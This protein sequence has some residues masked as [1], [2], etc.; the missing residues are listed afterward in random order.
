MEGMA[1]RVVSKQGAVIARAFLAEFA[2]GIGDAFESSGTTTS[3]TGAGIIETL[4]PSKTAQT[5]L[6]S[7][8]SEAFSR[9]GDFYMGLAEQMVP[10]IEINAGRN[11][12]VVFSKSVNLEETDEEKEKYEKKEKENGAK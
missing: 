4:D 3:I 1:G 5:G 2:S 6:S 10:G 11:V 8:L 7:G 12:D 9:L